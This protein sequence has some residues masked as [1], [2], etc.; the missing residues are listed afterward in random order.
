MA[1]SDEFKDKFIQV[2]T[3]VGFSVTKAVKIAK[4]DWKTHFQWMKD[5]KKYNKRFNEAKTEALDV[6]LEESEH[7]HRIL[8]LGIPKKNEEGKLVGWE[9]RPDGRAIEWFLSKRSPDYSDKLTLQHTSDE[10]FADVIK[11]ILS[12]TP[13]ETTTSDKDDITSD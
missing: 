6:L 1:Y 7:T 4:I 11:N 10:N 8:R 3:E 9:E 13:T 12:G 5:D 2:Y